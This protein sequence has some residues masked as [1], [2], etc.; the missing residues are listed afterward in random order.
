M[1]KKL[2]QVE[3]KLSQNVKKKKFYVLFLIL[4]MS[5]L[6]AIASSMV[7][8][9]LSRVLAQLIILVLQYVTLEGILNDY[10]AE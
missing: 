4:G 6:L 8:E 1:D 2:K 10:F 5:L 9:P 7:V 3:E